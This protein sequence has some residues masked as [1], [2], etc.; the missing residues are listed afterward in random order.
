MEWN[1]PFLPRACR[2]GGGAAACGAGRECGWARSW[3]RGGERGEIYCTRR[4]RWR[5]RWPRRCCGSLARPRG[6]RRVCTPLAAAACRARRAASVSPA[7]RRWCPARAQVRGAPLRALVGGGHARAQLAQA[8]SLAAPRTLAWGAPSGTPA[9]GARRRRNRAAASRARTAPRGARTA[10]ASP[11]RRVPSAAAGRRRRS[12]ARLAVMEA[13][14]GSRAP[15]VLAPASAPAATA[16]WGR[17]LYRGRAC[18]AAGSRSCGTIGAWGWAVAMGVIM[19]LVCVCVCGGGGGGDTHWRLCAQPECE[20]LHVGGVRAARDGELLACA[21]RVRRG[22][23]VLPEPRRMPDVH[24]GVDI[25]VGRGA[26]VQQVH[27]DEVGAGSRV[28]VLACVCVCVRSCV[29]L[30]A[31]VCASLCVCACRIRAL[32]WRGHSLVCMGR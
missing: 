4:L 10:P 14:P 32:Y 2:F 22:V 12:H 6:A 30:C 1:L 5:R 28:R 7:P 11:A 3:A 13:P 20:V 25:Q 17:R 29:G 18:R 23:S 24:G 27:D 9:R 31:P 16:P 19:F 21:R 26:R 8:A 15:R